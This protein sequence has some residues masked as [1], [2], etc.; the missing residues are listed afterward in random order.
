MT[1]C[2]RRLSVGFSLGFMIMA[3]LATIAAE[4]LAQEG[5]FGPAV[6]N[7]NSSRQF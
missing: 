1:R 3:A 7:M 6:A 2:V 4:S 5:V